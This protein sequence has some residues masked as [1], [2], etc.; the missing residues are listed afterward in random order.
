MDNAKK[1]NAD[2]SSAPLV[3]TISPTSLVLIEPAALSTST[4][5]TAIAIAACPVMTAWIAVGPHKEATAMTA[6]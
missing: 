4:P 6:V 2:F 5:L 1:T 3:T